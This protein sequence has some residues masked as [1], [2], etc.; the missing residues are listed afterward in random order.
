MV[1]IYFLKTLPNRS[2]P[3]KFLLTDRAI[4]ENGIAPGE[5]LVFTYRGECVYKARAK[6]ARLQNDGS[7]AEEYPHLFFVDVATIEAIKGTL[8]ELQTKLEQEVL[9]VSD[10]VNS[11][12][13][14]KFRDDEPAAVII[15]AYVS[16]AQS[17]DVAEQIALE[18]LEKQH[19]KGQGFLLNTKLRSTLENYAM[20]AAKA[21][22]KSDGFDWE[23]RSKNNPYDLCCR[24]GKEVVYVEVKGTQTTGDQIIL[25][26]G[27]VEFARGHK[28]QMALFVLH[29]IRVTESEGDFH[30]TE[31]TTKLINPWEVKDECLKP[32]SFMCRV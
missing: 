30:L 16:P 24:R 29:S 1:D 13:W 19:A 25:T 17:V 31:G 10:L 23:D 26:N 27:E 5:R 20:D 21:H 7:D 6:S 8:A 11:R 14:P 15:E 3:G 22:F 2:P 18:V 28:G 4:G 12:S 32:L 9:S